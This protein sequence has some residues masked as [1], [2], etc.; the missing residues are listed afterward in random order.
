M[1]IELYFGLLNNVVNFYAAF[2]SHVGCYRDRTDRSLPEHLGDVSSVDQCYQLVKNMG[3]QAFGV[4]YSKEC[5]SG[6]NAIRRYSIYGP[7][8]S[9]NNGMGGSWSS[10]VYR[11][12]LTGTNIESNLLFHFWWVDHEL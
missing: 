8:T 3:Y 2:Y 12:T 1:V 5:W 9:C 11:I 6:N 7:S 4:Q 10:D